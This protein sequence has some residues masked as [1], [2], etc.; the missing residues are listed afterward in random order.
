MYV[1][2]VNKMYALRQGRNSLLKT[3][4]NPVGIEE[5]VCTLTWHTSYILTS[6]YSNLVILFAFVDCWNY[7]YLH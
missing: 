1:L 6:N 3:C 4:P 2:P 7:L 5:N